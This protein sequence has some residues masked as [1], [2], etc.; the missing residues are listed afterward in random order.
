MNLQVKKIT[1]FIAVL[2][3]TLVI[4]GCSDTK[5][6]VVDVNKVMTDSPKVQQFEEQLKNDAKTRVDQLE[7]DKA[8]LSQE[9]LQKRS[10]EISSEMEKTKQELSKQLNDSMDKAL[11]E[12]A[13]EKKMSV[14]LYKNGVAQGGIDITDDVIKKMQ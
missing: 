10:M 3:I 11:D 1:G 9:E 12:I 13:K 14:I 8:S 2:A 7:K 6:G 5:I 4:G